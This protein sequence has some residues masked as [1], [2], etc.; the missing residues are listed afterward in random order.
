MG[1]DLDYQELPLES[2][3]F[4]KATTS[5]EYWEDF[6]LMIPTWEAKK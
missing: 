6:T 4:R 5:A 1:I 3:A 2:D